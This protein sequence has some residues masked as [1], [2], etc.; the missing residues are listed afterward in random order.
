MERLP[1]IIVNY[2]SGAMLKRCITELYNSED[3]TSIRTNF[4]GRNL[5]AVDS[6]ADIELVTRPE[7]DNFCFQ[8][9][10]GEC[11]MF[12][13]FQCSK[14]LKLHGPERLLYN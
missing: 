7:V 1:V 9:G 5:R 3:G 2:N 13:L 14:C 10:R 11:C 8:L 6:Y 12:K 4:T